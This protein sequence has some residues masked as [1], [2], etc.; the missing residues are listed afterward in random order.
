VAGPIWLKT[1]QQPSYR[2]CSPRPGHRLLLSRGWRRLWWRG[3]RRRSGRR[4]RSVPWCRWG[5][6]VRRLRGAAGDQVHPCPAAVQRGADV[7]ADRSG[8]E[9]SNPR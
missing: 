8:A 7:G 9:N 3:A 2:L 4:A 5:R 1:P 6:R